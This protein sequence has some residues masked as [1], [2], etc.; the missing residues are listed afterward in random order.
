MAPARSR[1]S[2]PAVHP[3]VEAFG[4]GATTIA[5]GRREGVREGE[6]RHVSRVASLLIVYVSVDD[7][8]GQDRGRRERLRELR[9][10]GQRVGRRVASGLDAG[11][12][13]VSVASCS[14][15]SRAS[16]RS[17]PPL[18]VH[19]SGRR[20]CPA[21][22]GDRARPSGRGQR[23]TDR[24]RRRRRRGV[25]ATFTPVGRCVRER[26]PGRAGRATVMVNVNVDV[27]PGAIAAGREGLR[28]AVTAAAP[29]G[30]SAAGG[31]TGSPV[32]TG[33][34][35]GATVVGGS[36]TG[37]SSAARAAELIMIVPTR[38]AA[39]PRSAHAVARPTCPCPFRPWP[40][41]RAPHVSPMRTRILVSAPTR[42][43]TPHPSLEPQDPTS[44][45]LAMSRPA[46]ETGR[47]ALCGL[48]Q[49][50]AP[51][52]LPSWGRRGRCPSGWCRG[53]RPSPAPGS[54]CRE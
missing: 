34:S 15:G 14:C 31:A 44:D 23:A 42:I 9:R 8:A 6:V 13:D 28:E 16:T 20:R 43:D 36:V 1:L 4:V 54:R 37:G 12:V 22:E 17:H 24:A 51:T 47:S 38:S 5:P 45:S 11:I 3:V 46:Q 53:A 39:A 48:A 41:T 32:W 2:V 49:P 27:P 35:W 50:P 18:T 52:A 26:E 19:E 29:T 10:D 7:T 21:R 33:G 40:I 30:G 25:D